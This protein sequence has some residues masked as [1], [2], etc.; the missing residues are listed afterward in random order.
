MSI[1]ITVCGN[2]YNYLLL[3]YD[4]DLQ[5][6]TLLARRHEGG[7]AAPL[8]LLGRHEGRQTQVA[9]LAAPASPIHAAPFRWSFRVVLLEEEIHVIF[10]L[11]GAIVCVGGLSS[12][13]EGVGRAIEKKNI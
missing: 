2:T 6:A 7:L 10:F 13:G 4:L 11:E 12:W 8:P 3:Q 5:R 9:A 1:F